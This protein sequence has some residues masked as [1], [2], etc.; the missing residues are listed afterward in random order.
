MVGRG[1]G[2][3]VRVGQS[4]AAESEKGEYGF[5]EHDCGVVL[6]VC[7]GNRWE[8]DVFDVSK[9]L[10]GRSIYR[11]NVCVQEDSHTP[12]LSLLNHAVLTI[13]EVKIPVRVRRC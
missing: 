10:C 12:P 2:L 6:S 7:D 11:R 13:L 4:S 5:G 1:S 3:L 9:S 8:V